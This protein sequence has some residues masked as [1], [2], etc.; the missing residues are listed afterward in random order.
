METIK[1]K[2]MDSEVAYLLNK[3]IKYLIKKPLAQTSLMPTEILHTL[4][5]EDMC[6]SGSSAL[7]RCSLFWKSSLFSSLKAEFVM[8]SFSLYIYKKKICQNVGLT[9]RVKLRIFGDGRFYDTKENI[10]GWSFF[11]IQK[12][13]IWRWSHFC[14]R[15]RKHVRMVRHWLFFRPYYL[16]TL[17][18]FN[19]L[20]SGVGATQ[21]SK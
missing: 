1:N 13:N 21:C 18:Y 15:K 17:D 19:N 7:W 2:A 4:S 20:L 6:I 12:Q 8:V 11:V 10:W 5:V 3:A 16:S 9:R 14:D